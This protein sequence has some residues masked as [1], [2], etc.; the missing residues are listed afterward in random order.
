MYLVLSSY[1]FELK[2]KHNRKRCGELNTH[3]L[4]VVKSHKTSHV[5]FVFIVKESQ[6]GKLM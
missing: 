2:K 4:M 1:P 6:I 5:N 3:I